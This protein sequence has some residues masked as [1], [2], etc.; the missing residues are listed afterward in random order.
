MP[1]FILITAIIAGIFISFVVV[2][3][4]LAKQS[5]MEGET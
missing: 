2:R 1:W 3:K 4:R 5:A